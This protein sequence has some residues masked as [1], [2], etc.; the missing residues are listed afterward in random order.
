MTSVVGGTYMQLFYPLFAGQVI[1]FL[2]SLFGNSVII[3]HKLL[4]FTRTKKVSLYLS[5]NFN[6]RHISLL[7]L[8]LLS[9]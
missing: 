4:N 5:E 8:L 7:L 6:W 2:A 9:N 1:V 3:H